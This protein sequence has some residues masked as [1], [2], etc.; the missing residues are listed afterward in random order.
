MDA[1][2]N[3]VALQRKAVAHHARCTDAW[4]FFNVLTGEELLETVDT[5]LPAHRERL[6]P[7]TETLSMFLAQALNDDRSC[8]AAVNGSAARRMVSW[9]S[10]ESNRN[11]PTVTW[12]GAGFGSCP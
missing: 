6:F 12:G 2:A 8:Q 10:G 11:H 1:S 4:Q 3:A 5:A 7:P 9:S